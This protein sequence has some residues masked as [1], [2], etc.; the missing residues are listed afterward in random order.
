MSGI[1]RNKDG[2]LTKGEI[3]LTNKE[4]TMKDV[5]QVNKYNLCQLSNNKLKILFLN[6]GSTV[7]PPGWQSHPSTG[8]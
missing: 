1:L 2:Y 6:L 4:A 3:K 5:Q 7:V 8:G